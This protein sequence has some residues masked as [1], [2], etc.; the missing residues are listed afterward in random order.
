MFNACRFNRYFFSHFNRIVT[1][2]IINETMLV[3]TI[4]GSNNTIII[5]WAQIYMY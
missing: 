4:I 3:K 5:I 2:N 1:A